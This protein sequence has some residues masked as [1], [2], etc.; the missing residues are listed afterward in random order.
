MVSYKWKEDDIELEVSMNDNWFKYFDNQEI[1]RKAKIDVS[2][3]QK[4]RE[5][6][7]GNTRHKT[8]A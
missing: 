4:L 7:D 6:Y 5:K 1:A 3:V 2:I 8:A